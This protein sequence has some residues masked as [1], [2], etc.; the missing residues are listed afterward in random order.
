MINEIKDLFKNI[1]FNTKG[2]GQKIKKILNNHLEIKE[3]IENELKKYPMYDSSYYFIRTI[4]DN[5][6]KDKLIKC[7]AC[8][9]SNAC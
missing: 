6:K 4:M 8:R 3:Y 1:D 7:K 2:I 5:I 9:K